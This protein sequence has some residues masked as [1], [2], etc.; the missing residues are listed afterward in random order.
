MGI[1]SDHPRGA[2]ALR[3]DYD[4]ADDLL[5]DYDEGLAAGTAA[6]EVTRELTP[7][8]RVALTLAFPG[9]VTPITLE[10]VVDAV[11]DGRTTV[12]VRAQLPQLAAIVERV[13]RHDPAV[14][15]Q[16]ARILVVEDNHH[17]AGLIAHGMGRRSDGPRFVMRTV[18]DGREALDLLAHETFDAVIVD[19]YLPVVDGPQI[20]TAIRGSGEAAHTPVLAISAGGEPARRAAM[21]AG[22]DQFLEKPIR[23]RDLVGGL[24]ELLAAARP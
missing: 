12:D 11:D 3:I 10:G 6:V 19:V 16:V 2:V 20:I 15:R 22:A 14:V 23:L 17:V 8:T 7:G 4:D 9:L 1:D 24:S 18:T 5:R 13:R 21:K